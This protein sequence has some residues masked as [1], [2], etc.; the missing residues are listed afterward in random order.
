MSSGISGC[1][2][3]SVSRPPTLSGARRVENQPAR[4]LG[5]VRSRGREFIEADIAGPPH[6]EVDLVLFHE[7]SRARA[8][9]LRRQD[10]GGSDD[11]GDG[12]DGKKLGLGHDFGLLDQCL[13]RVYPRAS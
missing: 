1:T 9:G 8:A 3:G 2:S 12:G 11:G 7:H 5:C 4:L 10:G 6:L 13:L